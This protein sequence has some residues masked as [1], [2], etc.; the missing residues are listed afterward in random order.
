MLSNE[1]YVI[2]SK[3]KIKNRLKTP[4]KKHEQCTIWQYIMSLGKEFYPFKVDR[5]SYDV[6]FCK[7]FI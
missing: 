3:H 4:E 1:R 2:N 6:G 7:I 5:F